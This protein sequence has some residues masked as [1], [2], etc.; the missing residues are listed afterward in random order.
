MIAEKQSTKLVGVLGSDPCYKVTGNW[1]GRIRSSGLALDHFGK[2][3][4]SWYRNYMSTISSVNMTLS[5]SIG[6]CHLAIPTDKIY[7][8]ALIHSTALRPRSSCFGPTLRSIELATFSASYDS[9]WFDTNSKIKP[10]LGLQAML[11]LTPMQRSLHPSIFHFRKRDIVKSRSDQISP[12]SRN[13]IFQILDDFEAP[14]HKHG[15]DF[16]RYITVQR[17]R[18]IW[19]TLPV[20]TNLFLSRV[21]QG[22]YQRT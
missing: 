19:E 8:C 11:Q 14:W 4:C 17:Y 22:H 20:L 2:L 3:Q 7:K 5:V 16:S 12:N 18:R 13:C 6:L 9:N 21:R 15:S 10:G 1:C